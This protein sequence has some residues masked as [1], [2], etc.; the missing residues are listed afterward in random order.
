MGG[1]KHVTGKNRFVTKEMENGEIGEDN[2]N[3]NKLEKE[4]EENKRNEK[5]SIITRKRKRNW[6]GKQQI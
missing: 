6:G 1:R 3:N 5:L 4:K 2:S